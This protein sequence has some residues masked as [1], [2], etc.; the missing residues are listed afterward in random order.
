[1]P[2][3]VSRAISNDALYPRV[4]HEMRPIN[5]VLVLR[6]AFPALVSAQTT[7]GLP[8][9]SQSHPDSLRATCRDGIIHLGEFASIIRIYISEV[10]IVGNSKNCEVPAQRLEGDV[11]AAMWAAVLG[12]RDG[13]PVEPEAFICATE[14]AVLVVDYGCA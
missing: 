2:W 9:S 7:I 1:M 11:L 10:G 3:R 13:E 6:M 8:L 4:R 5:F 14:R 12:C